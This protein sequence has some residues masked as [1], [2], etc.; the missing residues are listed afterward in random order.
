MGGGWR[1]AIALLAALVSSGC[2]TGNG[3]APS[4][5]RYELF[6][7]GH[8]FAPL[9]ASPEESQFRNSYGVGF[10]PN[11]LDTHLAVTQP[12]G[13]L[14]LLRREGRRP[15][16]GLELSIEAS[17]VATFD[18]SSPG[19]DLLSADYRFSY[20][21]SLRRGPASA[22]L[23]YRHLSTH[24]G[25]EYLLERVRPRMLENTYRLEELEG[26]FARE[27]GR[28]RLYGG[29]GHAFSAQPRAVKRNRLQAGAELTLPTNARWRET[30]KASYLLAAHVGATEDRR[31]RPAVSVRT[32]F[33][34]R[35][36]TE[37]PHGASRYRMLL[38]FHDGPA[39]VGQFSRFYDVRYVGIGC[40]VVP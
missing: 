39:P 29:A 30:A 8:L 31:W 14:A 27:I 6:P 17:V 2:A 16:D 15:G 7:A 13:T 20:P 32:G 33:E 25:D 38:E 40:Y 35:R 19:W 9:V 4:R 3:G 11:E 26:L 5:P 21:L 18:M 23:R 28:W 10:A 37:G 36:G 24:V 1:R 34:V 22:I 12:G